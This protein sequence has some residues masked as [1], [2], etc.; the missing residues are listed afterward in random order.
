MARE[1]CRIA[2]KRQADAEVYL[3]QK[4]GP[5]WLASRPRRLRSALVSST[6]LWYR[7]RVRRCSTSDSSR[8]SREKAAITMKARRK[9]AGPLHAPCLNFLASLSNRVPAR[10]VA[11][12]PASQCGIRGR[13][14]ASG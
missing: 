9:Q 4:G 13:P 5:V 1:S 12:K 10:Y 7:W 8:A 11:K 2:L 14:T 3:P 6:T